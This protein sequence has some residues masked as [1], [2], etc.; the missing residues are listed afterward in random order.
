MVEQRRYAVST[1]VQL[2]LFALLWLLADWQLCKIIP[3]QSVKFNEYGLQLPF[4]TK[5]V[6]KLSHKV[7]E[8]HW[9]MNISILLVML[10][11]GVAVIIWF[12]SRRLV[13]RFYYRMRAVL[14]QLLP[15]S[16]NAVIFLSWLLP[17][18]KL[19]AALQY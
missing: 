7:C 12:Q 14:I 3:S 19:R 18:M 1:A 5:F 2:L 11:P 10:L 16:V 13:S 9:W 17:A 4:L 6:I 15:L 8:L